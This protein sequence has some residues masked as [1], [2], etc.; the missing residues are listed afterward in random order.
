MEIGSRGVRFFGGIA[1]LSVLGCGSAK[2]DEDIGTV[3]AVASALVT[4]PTEDARDFRLRFTRV[5]TGAFS[6]QLVMHGT[7][8][9]A[10][11]ID[12]VALPGC[13]PQSTCVPSGELFLDVPRDSIAPLEATVA[14][15]VPSG[16]G[17]VAKIGVEFEQ[18]RADPGDSLTVRVDDTVVDVCTGQGGFA[19]AGQMGKEFCL[20]SSSGS[21]WGVCFVLDAPTTPPPVQRLLFV[22]WCWP[23]FVQ[24][25]FDD[26]VE[27]SVNFFTTHSA[28]GDCDENSGPFG[29]R[30]FEFL[31]APAACLPSYD[32]ILGALPNGLTS[33]ELDAIVF[34]S[35]EPPSDPLPP[36]SLFDDECVAG[37]A[38]SGGFMTSSTSAPTPYDGEYIVFAH[39]YGH[40][41]LNLGE[42]YRE[43]FFSSEF[44]WPNHV[45]AELGCDPATC[46]TREHVCASVYGIPLNGHVCAG[47]APLDLE[48]WTWGDPT[49]V[50]HSDGGCIMSN[51]SAP[52]WDSGNPLTGEGAHRS[53]CEA[54]WA[55]WEAF[56]PRCTD[57]FPGQVNRL[58]VTGNL[59]VKQVLNLKSVSIGTGRVGPNLPGAGP[60]VI[61]VTNPSGAELGRMEVRKAGADPQDLSNNV[62]FWMRMPV[63]SSV[64]LPLTLTVIEEGVPGSRVTAGG[65]VPTTVFGGA[66]AE[67]TGDSGASVTLDGSASSDP[68]GD[69]LIFDWSSPVPLTDED[70]AMPTG[71]FPLGETTVSLTVSDGSGAGGTVSGAVMVTDTQAPAI[72]LGDVAALPVCR[73]SGAEVA[74]PVPTA[75]DACTGSVPV[76]GTVIAS[77]NPSLTLPLVL[78]NGNATLP[79][80]THTVEWT[81][82]D[83]SGNTATKQQVVE[84]VPALH[85]TRSFDL[86]DRAQ[87]RQGA[88]FASV[89]SSGT[90]MSSLGVESRLH[91]LL[92]TPPIDVRDRAGVYGDLRTAG[93]LTLG[94]QVL[95]L[96]A[97]V[98][99]Q[100]LGLPPAPVVS[101]SFP[102]AAAGSLTV[103]PYTVGSM[104]PGSYDTIT[105]GAG[106]TLNLTAGGSYYVRRLIL[107]PQSVLIATSPVD[108]FVQTELVYRG[109]FSGFQSSTVT[110]AGAATLY[111]EA[112]ATLSRLLVPGAG[113]VVRGNLRAGRI[114]AR[115]LVV[116]P[117]R[118]LECD[119]ALL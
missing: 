105:V 31:R 58:E 53:W 106:A 79:A 28:L 57:T 45:R 23:N 7:V 73:L 103:S 91:D 2:L 27:R 69:T 64:T 14:F 19:C 94:N 55:Q 104:A 26:A 43:P 88:G 39:E 84:V 67:C 81:A 17:T 93:S 35:H 46:C 95:V 38:L 41:F 92:S 85:A 78:T 59:D 9:G 40:T 11:Q 25:D 24:Q 3:D 108:L 42:E 107:E 60:L 117:D 70:S 118:I 116:D 97:T 71:T 63:A 109:V 6:G 62:H 77:T 113:L 75:L 98:Q 102:P 10:V 13:A 111:L 56:G 90:V 32:D 65:S 37:S 1:F 47:N 49:P 5:D 74:L 50:R 21:G 61:A 114:L 87:I 72:T 112:P 66:T 86:R 52:G 115:D 33:A 68:D 18:D 82:T 22:P 29:T 54:C 80:G 36:G 83:S 12:N 51:A 100:P 89:A 110:Y 76:T 15:S 34:V 4:Q 99:G 48:G 30:K 119:G 96:G 20:S 44:S 101:V 8:N 16:G